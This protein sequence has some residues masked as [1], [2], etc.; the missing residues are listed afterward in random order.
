MWYRFIFS[1]IKRLK[2]AENGHGHARA[3]QLQKQAPD[4]GST[5]AALYLIFR[6]RQ[7]QRGCQQ[8]TK[9]KP[10]NKRTHE[11]VSVKI[12]TRQ[13]EQTTHACMHVYMHEAEQ[14]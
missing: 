10:S 2:R 5:E 8:S 3:R 13:S 1:K 7:S 9:D 4:A 12:H 6:Q 14:N 11:W